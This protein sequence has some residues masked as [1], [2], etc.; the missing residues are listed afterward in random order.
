MNRLDAI[1]EQ[2]KIAL[3]GFLMFLILWGFLSAFHVDSDFSK[4]VS[5][6]VSTL[7]SILL[8]VIDPRKQTVA[9]AAPGGAANNFPATTTKE[10]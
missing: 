6:A 5:T 3:G 9:P 4:F 2:A 7:W 10:Q 1:G 8:F